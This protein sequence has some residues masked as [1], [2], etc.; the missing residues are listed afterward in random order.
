MGRIGRQRFWGLALLA[1]AACSRAAAPAEGDGSEPEPSRA[2]VLP[3]HLEQAVRSFGQA[4]AAVVAKGVAARWPIVD[5]YPRAAGSC[6]A[7]GHQVLTTGAGG[8][9]V[10]DLER[11]RVSS[12]F[13]EYPSA[14][15]SSDAKSV[16]AVG[17][18]GSALWLERYSVESGAK[19]ESQR[20]SPPP[21]G[22][23]TASADA[24]VLPEVQR[25]VVAVDA[26]AWLIDLGTGR[27]VADWPTRDVD[28]TSAVAAPGGEHIAVATLH[29]VT[30]HALD[31]RKVR[32]VELPTPLGP[33]RLAALE[34]GALLGLQVSGRGK[35]DAQR[36]DPASGRVSTTRIEAAAAPI[37]WTPAF[38]L[39]LFPDGEIR[40]PGG[41]RLRRVAGLSPHD[42]PRPGCLLADG[43]VL[44]LPLLA[45]G[46][47]ALVRLSDAARVDLS[48]HG[49]LIVAVT[50]DLEVD[51]AARELPARLEVA[52]RRVELAAPNAP[53]L[54]RRSGLVRSF[55]GGGGAP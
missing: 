39:L 34:S 38:D 8:V 40:K 30:L 35:L 17:A 1:L 44:A 33:R 50:P 47:L 49:E 24:F 14:A 42:A 27:V 53:P 29:G 4:D 51:A 37:G 54:R 12:F 16:I 46:T 5:G 31:G 22:E 18:R 2:A 21:R 45:A 36:I 43:R 19:L 48:R 10:W 28:V 13:I 3:A 11:L 7:A 9:S 41:E 26:K 25:A 23:S 32:E 20:L 15:F 6:D 52:G 55:L